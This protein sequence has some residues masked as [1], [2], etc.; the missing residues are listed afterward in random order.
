MRQTVYRSLCLVLL[1]FTGALP[2]LHAQEREPVST[3]PPEELLRA[4]PMVGPAT[5][6][7]TVIWVQTWEPAAVQIMYRE[8]GLPEDSSF[9]ET[10]V[11]YTFGEEDF[12]AHIPITHLEPGKTY[13]YKLVLNDTIVELPYPLRFTTQPLWQ[14]RT[15]PPTF[16]VAV[17]SCLYVND[18]LYDR[19]GEPYGG[20]YEILTHIA[21]RNPDLMIWLGDNTYL[22][23]ADFDSPAMMAYRYAHTRQLPELQPLLARV[24]HYA[25]WDD[26]DFG[27]NDSD[28]GYVFKGASLFLF[29]R[30]WANP[31]YGM[32]GVP[33]VFTKFTWGDVDFFLL[34]DRYYRSPNRAPVDSTK[35]MLGE[36][37]L[38]WL[39][40]ALTYS[41]APFKII[42]NGNQVL[43]AYTRFESMA[44]MFPADKEKLLKAIVERGIEGVIFL[45]GDRHQTEL[46]K[47]QPEGF[48]PIYEYTNSP[49]TSGPSTGKEENPLRVPGTLVQ[50]RN[51]GLMTFSGPRTDRELKITT[52]NAEGK[53]L[54]EYT[55]RARDLKVPRSNQ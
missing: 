23:E 38:Q 49:L 26:H 16:T 40:D 27:P 18:P 15:D 22:R 11:F 3:L 9:V 30:Y 2:L 32:P 4:G 29:Q 43:N 46:L 50:E 28:R 5:L 8:A 51:F 41:R 17:G 55:I 20:H 1:L 7:A 47:L 52:I 33:G 42:A 25:I 54:W 19:P 48:Y 39:I 53:V 14:W 24:H 35:T 36:K 34:D 10:P 45:T 44:S 13:E 21:E 31:T 37:Q 12:I 6:R